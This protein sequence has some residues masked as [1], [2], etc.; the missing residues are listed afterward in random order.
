MVS[1][2]DKGHDETEKD[3]Q[4]PKVRISVDC[5]YLP[6]SYIEYSKPNRGEKV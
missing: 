5:L 2:K 6:E 3:F 4:N 1:L